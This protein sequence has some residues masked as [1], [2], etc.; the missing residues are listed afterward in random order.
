MIA[1]AAAG[2]VYDE[3]VPATA[4]PAERVVAR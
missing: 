4:G 3:Q 1:P 2:G